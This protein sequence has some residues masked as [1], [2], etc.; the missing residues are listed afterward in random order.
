MYKA[1][2]YRIYPTSEQETLLVK[3]FGCA[4]WFWNYALNLCQETYKN[5]GKG[6]TRGYIQ[7]L[8]PALKKEYEWLA[9]PYSQCLQV[10]ALNLSTAYKNFF[11]KRAMLPKFKSKHGRQSISYPQNVKFDGDKIYLPKIDWVC[12]ERHRDFEGDVKTVTVS[13]NPD[14]KYFVSVLVDDG[15][16]NPE[17]MPVDKAIG[18]DVGL[19][20]FA[21]TSDGSKFDNP[22][23]FIKHQRNLKR[24]Q[25]KL[26]KKKKGSQNRKKARLVVAKVHAKIARC[27]EDFLHKLSRK[28]VNENQVIAVE[29]LNIKGMVKNHNLAKAISDV[30]WGMFCTMLKYKAESEGKQYIEIDRWFPSSKTCHVCLNRVDNLSLDVRAWTCKHCGTHHDRDVNE[31]INIRNETLRII[32]L[33]TS[34]SACGG[35]VSRSGK[36]SVLLDA[37][38]VESGSQPCTA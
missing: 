38:P 37:I 11:D 31:A 26:S 18:I 34:E 1:Y 36:T 9:E 3:S 7:G 5:T 29:N 28:I 14:G 23:F 25:Q 15:K 30:G 24:K 16:A 27:R 20:H 2:K 12:F 33:G 10:V 17:L 21:I 8:L 13:R 19:T 22:R 35:D 4:R 32:L 6:L